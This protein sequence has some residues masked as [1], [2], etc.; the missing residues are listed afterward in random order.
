MGEN[1]YHRVHQSIQEKHRALDGWL[2]TAPQPEKIRCVDCP[3][4]SPVREHLHILDESLQKADNGTLGVCEVCH[5]HVEEK[6]L[7]IDYTASICLD[8]LSEPERRR[9]EAEL[10]FSSEIQ[11]ALL[12]QQAPTIPGLEVGAFSRPAQI[13]G[14]DYFDFIRFGNGAYGLVIADVMGHG[15]SASLLM[16]SLQTALQTLIPDADSSAEVIQRVNRYY[17]HNVNL[18]TFVTVFLGQFDP[19]QY[20]LSYCNAGHNPPLLYQAQPG[21]AVWL[22]PTGAAV[23]LVEEYKLRVEQ[24]LLRPGDLV[25]LY[26]DGVTEAVDAQGEP[27]GQE[28]LVRLVAQN[29]DR[30]AQ[31]IV[32]AL[33]IGLEDFIGTAAL[34]DD[35]T[36]VVCKVSG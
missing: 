13:I 14:G 26:T 21:Q 5:G 11:R 20:T 29:A 2:E 30:S 4:D 35:V 12:P 23:G 6:V 27:F 32:S 15:V 22:K 10:E 19:G 1:I 3:N 16:S 36:L 25:L 18:T 17:L 7:E 31:E 28:R 34:A 9:L 8:C 33:R 24:V